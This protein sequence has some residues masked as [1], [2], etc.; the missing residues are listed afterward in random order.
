MATTSNF[1]VQRSQLSFD[2]VELERP[3][4]GD[5]DL[6]LALGTEAVDTGIRSA[7]WIYDQV[8]DS[9]VWTSPVETFFGFPAG[10]AGFLV[11]DG[12]AP[13]RPDP[14]SLR[15]GS[16]V[17]VDEPPSTAALGDALLAPILSAVRAGVPPS[18]VRADKTPAPPDTRRRRGE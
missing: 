7:S 15:V 6:E 10:A 2:R 5:R 16:A 18:E 17:A 13:D 11:P 9:V 4:L 3:P 14:D 8:D 1:G 12:E